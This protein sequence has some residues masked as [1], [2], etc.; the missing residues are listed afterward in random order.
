MLIDDKILIPAPKFSKYLQGTFHYYGDRV[1]EQPSWLE[2]L[3]GLNAVTCDE[4]DK[5]PHNYKLLHRID[6]SYTRWFSICIKLL[7]AAVALIV[8]AQFRAIGYVV[9][10]FASVMQIYN[11][12]LY[13][14]EKHKLLTRRA[15]ELSMDKHF[16]AISSIFFALIGLLFLRRPILR[17]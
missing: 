2:I 3:S 11:T 9:L 6:S 8:Q 17:H 14:E 7:L 5:L 13:F 10:T 16:A 4:A 15:R 12:K 1:E